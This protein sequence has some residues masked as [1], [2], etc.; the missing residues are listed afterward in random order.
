VP[1]WRAGEDED[2]NSTRRFLSTVAERGEKWAAKGLPNR[3]LYVLLNFR[4]SQESR[5][6]EMSFARYFRLC[7][8]RIECDADGLRVGGVA[9]LAR[10]AKGGWTRRDEGDLSRELSKLYGFPLDFGRICRGVDAVAASLA[11]GELARAQIAALLL[12]LPDPPAAEG[13]QPNALEERFLARDLIACG[14]LKA[15]A[16]W[17]DKH[18]RT[19]APPNPGWFAPTAGAAATDEPKTSASRAAGAP[20]RGGASQAFLAPAPAAGAGSLLAEDLSATALEGLAALAERFFAPAILFGAIFI[21]S[22]NPSVEDG[23]VPGRPDIAYHWDHGEGETAITFTALV[24][25][26]WRT[27]AVGGAAPNGLVFDRDGRAVARVVSGPDGRQTL[28]ATVDAL[29]RAVADLQRKEG[30]PAAAPIPD[31]DEPRLC[32]KPTNEPATTKSA[33]S[34]AYQQYVTGLRYPLAIWFGGM[35]IDGCDPPTGDLLEAKADID[36]MFDRNDD[37]YWWIK[38]QNNPGIQMLDQAEAALAAGRLVDWHAQTEK[39]YRGLTKIRDSLKLPER[40]VVTVVY[41]PN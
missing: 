37:V 24:N 12:R 11:N 30:E 10:E 14:L 21:P 31:D 13:A 15:D 38:P 2:E 6:G 1:K 36:F 16:D 5:M 33:N 26:Q 35:F 17:D 29:D 34:I 27:V 32:P 28:V 41:D 7:P 19:G 39:G 20:S 3:S 18:P 25:G 8:G 9:L 22:A 23:R 4:I 40:L